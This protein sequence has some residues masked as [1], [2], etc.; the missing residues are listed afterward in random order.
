MKQKQKYHYESK[1]W[2]HEI[3]T[4][5]FKLLRMAA[6]PIVVVL[7][8]SGCVEIRCVLKL[9]LLYSF[10]VVLNNAYVRRLHN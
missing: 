6:Y 10:F 8:K 1:T 5:S 2:R 9:W 4:K 7:R 3:E